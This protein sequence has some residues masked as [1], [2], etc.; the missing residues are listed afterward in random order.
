LRAARLQEQAG[1]EGEGSG[2]DHGR[3]RKRCLT[4]P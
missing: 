4:V 3:S 1:D 2:K